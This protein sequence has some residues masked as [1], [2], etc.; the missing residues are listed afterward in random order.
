MNLQECT[1]LMISAVMD[2]MWIKSKGVTN[3]LCYG[4]QVDH[5]SQ[6]QHDLCLMADDLERFER[7]FDMAWN[8]INFKRIMTNWMKHIVRERMENKV[9]E[10]TSKNGEY[11]I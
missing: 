2:D 3:Y 5:P 4:C 7:T 6:I 1:E 10:P 11:Y 9:M 8:Q